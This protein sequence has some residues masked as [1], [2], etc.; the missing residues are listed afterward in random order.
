MGKLELAITNLAEVTANE[1]HNT[2]KRTN[3]KR[4]KKN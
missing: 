2:N 3:K 4:Y 1:M